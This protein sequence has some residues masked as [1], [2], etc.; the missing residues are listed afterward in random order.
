MPPSTTVI[1]MF[2]IPD[3]YSWWKREKFLLS[4]K[5]K[6]GDGDEESEEDKSKNEKNKYMLIKAETLK[7]ELEVSLQVQGACFMEEADFRR[8]VDFQSANKSLVWHKALHKLKEDKQIDETYPT[9]ATTIIVNA[10]LD[11]IRR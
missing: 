9:T 4:F 2:V 10:A 11:I 7:R 3:S 5:L 1:D 6:C 8:L